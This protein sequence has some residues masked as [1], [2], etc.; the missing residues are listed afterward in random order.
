MRT[1]QVD[2]LFIYRKRRGE[3]QGTVAKRFRVTIRKYVA[4]EN[5][6]VDIPMR[7]RKKV[8]ALKPFERCVLL[9]RRNGWTQQWVA[10]CMG[11]TRVWLGLME[12]G[13]APSKALE[14]WWNEQY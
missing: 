10:T 14:E 11:C 13:K 7:Y 6:T 8:G 9:R 2:R 4:W 12:N 1:T 5:G 3:S